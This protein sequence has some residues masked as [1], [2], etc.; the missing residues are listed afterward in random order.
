MATHNRAGEITFEHLNGLTYRI[1]LT[2]YTKASSTPADRCKLDIDFGDGTSEEVDRSNGNNVNGCFQGEIIPGGVDIKFNQYIVEH[3]FSGPGEFLISVL[4]P[5]RNSG[6][7]N[8]PNSISQ[9]F[10]LQTRLII[11]PFGQVQGNNSPILLNPPIDEG[12]LNRVYEHNPAA[13]DPDGDSLVYYLVEPLGIGGNPIQGYELPDQIPNP[14][15]DNVLTLDSMNGTLIW[16]SP[17]SIGEYNVAFV[18]EE[19]RKLATGQ[20]VKVGEVLR[21][22]QITIKNCDNDPPKIAQQSK[23]CIEAGT[24]FSRTIIANDPDNGDRVTLT[25]S[26]EP[27]LLADAP[28][29]FSQPV[30]A[31]NSISQIFRWNTA[32]SNVRSNDYQLVFKATDNG[33]PK[34][35]DYEILNIEVVAPAVESFQANASRNTIELAWSQA[36]CSEAVGYR[37]YRKTDSLGFVP[38]DCETGV[39]GYTGYSLLTE[40]NDLNQTTFIDDNNGLGLVHGFKYCYLIISYFSDGAE[41][42]ASQEVCAELEKDLP[43]ITRVSVNTTDVVQGSDSITWSAPVDLDPIQWPPPYRYKLERTALLDDFTEIWQSGSTSNVTLLDTLYRDDNLNTRDI[44]YRYRVGLYSGVDEDFVGYSQEATSPFLKATPLDNRVRLRWDIDVPW[45]NERYVIQREDNQGV[46]QTL[47]TIS[48]TEF[49]DENRIN[50]RTYCYRVITL[51][52]YTTQGFIDPIV[53]NSQVRCVV[54]ED[55]QAPCPPILR[56]NTSCDS[57]FNELFWTNP[58]TTCDTVDD[59]VSYNI[60]FTPIQGNEFKPY[61]TIP[62]ANQLTV[63]L[64]TLSSLAGCYYI[65]SVDSFSNES[66]PSNVVCAD[67]C[68]IYRL[69][70]V[71][72]P[73]GDGYNDFFKPFPYR[74]VESV[75]IRIF[76][77][78]GKEVF[79]ET[80]PNIMWEGTDMETGQDVPEGTYF[81]VCT[82]NEIRLTGIV[83]RIIKGSL[84][85]LRQENIYPKQ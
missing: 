11:P 12:C 51:G 14:S 50:G 81:Y 9:V 19:W 36:P 54:P 84:T 32:C 76:S 18:I 80:D 52:R 61:L 26:G 34:L 7:K 42:Y 79:Y 55:R 64:D 67:N 59:V 21:D 13:Y 56:L 23:V 69:P 65:T 72:T 28:A 44:Q 1:T 82:V 77:R 62:D 2:T 45:D 33:D 35:V 37:I 20:Y 38:N 30:S 17:K 47:D 6:I 25:A 57:V 40:I 3:T 78:W 27:L 60:Y 15:P 31:I 66:P 22:M 24:N 63:F 46:L 74:F 5:N 29:S 39:P 58:N 71:F 41:S 8:I 43:V 48:S 70:N 68:P 49:L 4:D 10:Y 73:G 83:P 53:N 16:D 75:E 85:L